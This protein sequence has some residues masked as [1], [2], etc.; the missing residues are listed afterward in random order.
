MSRRCRPPYDPVLSAGARASNPRAPDQLFQAVT[1]NFL[2]AAK[3]AV[4]DLIAAAVLWDSNSERSGWQVL[5][6]EPTDIRP[7]RPPGERQKGPES[8]QPIS[9]RSPRQL[10]QTSPAIGSHFARASS[11]DLTI[12]ATLAEQ[13][14]VR[15]AWRV[16]PP[17]RSKTSSP[18][19][20]SDSERAAPD[21]R[22]LARAPGA[23]TP[24]RAHS[25]SCCSWDPA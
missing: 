11:C 21:A 4:V 20:T 23:G 12:E 5:V 22:R 19:S 13:L 17:P 24:A 16:R 7:Q 9:A 6:S 1:A 25:G 15:D 14:T 10:L 18:L 3:V 8:A 2:A